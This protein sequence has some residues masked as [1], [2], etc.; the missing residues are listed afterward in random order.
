MTTIF[1]LGEFLHISDLEK[2]GNFFLSY[3]FKKKTNQE[4]GNLTNLWKQ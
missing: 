4:M 2:Y 1:M 3:S